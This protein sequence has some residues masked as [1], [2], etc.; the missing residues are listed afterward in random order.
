MPLKQSFRTGSIF[1]EIFCSLFI[2]SQTVLAQDP[3]I[4]QPFIPSFET[5]SLLLD[6]LFGRVK[7]PSLKV[8]FIMILRFEPNQLPESQVVVQAWRDGRLDVTEYRLTDSAWKSLVRYV[9]RNGKEDI[10][11]VARTLK[12]QV[13]PV[14]LPESTGE[15]W[16]ASLFSALRE[17]QIDLEKAAAEVR[18]DG[19]IEVVLDGATYNLRYLQGDREVHWTFSDLDVGSKNWNRPLGRWMNRVRLE[20]ESAKQGR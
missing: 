10:Q 15:S 4:A 14:K 12:V 9:D 2:L 6:S 3:A 1:A 7:P 17:E 13:T 18:K 16:W 5:H 11:A 8:Y 19:T 20:V